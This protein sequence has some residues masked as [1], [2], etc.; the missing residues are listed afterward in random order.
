MVKSTLVAILVV[1]AAAANCQVIIDQQPSLYDLGGGT[2]GRVGSISD[3]FS[4]LG[5]LSTY[6]MDD[7][8]ISSNVL[9]GFVT[10]YGI[11]SGGSGG[12]GHVRILQNRDHLSPGIIFLDTVSGSEMGGNWNF[13]LQ[14]IPLLAGSYWIE[15]YVRR[16]FATQGQWL[17]AHSNVNQGPPP[18]GVRGSEYYIQNP[19]SGSGG[20]RGW[21]TGLAIPGSDPRN[22][23][24]PN[25][26]RDLAFR[27]DGIGFP[28]PASLV[29]LGAGLAALLLR[30]RKSKN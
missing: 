25:S 26:P 8:T 29:A 10:V 9:L 19:A 7:F 14:A 28:E 23:A 12:V 13:V 1:C 17:W 4:D 30:R 3:E 22:P 24:N 2:M 6:C 27:I 21:G 18:S 16:D 5:D 11:D 20:G 15:F